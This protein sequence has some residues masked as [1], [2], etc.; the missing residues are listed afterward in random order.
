VVSNATGSNW[1]TMWRLLMN[2]LLWCSLVLGR[3]V[4]QCVDLFYET[5]WSC[6]EKHVPTRYSGCEQK[7]PWMTRKLTSLKNNKARALKKSKDS[8][9]QCLK[10]DAIDNCECKRLR[11]KFVFSSIQMRSR[12]FC[13]IWMSTRVP[14]PMAYHRS[15]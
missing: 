9:K 15:L 6:F 3:G 8:E 4:N 12:A 10:E 1:R 7:L 2:S 14:A 5:V 13:R 11:E